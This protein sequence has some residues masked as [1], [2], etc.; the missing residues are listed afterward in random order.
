MSN[1]LREKM[2]IKGY[3]KDYLKKVYPDMEIK[4]NKL[5]KCPKNCS[6]KNTAGL[7]KDKLECYNPE[8]K[9]FENIF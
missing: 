5:F 4:E 7:I 2:I 3:F 1:S 9:G 8:C 6:D